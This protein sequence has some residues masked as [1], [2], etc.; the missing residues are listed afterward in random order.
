MIVV[1]E[2]TTLRTVL[3]PGKVVLGSLRKQIKETLGSK[4]INSVPPWSLHQSWPLTQVPVLSS[5]SDFAL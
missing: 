5:H 4:P 3:T 2:A 1:G